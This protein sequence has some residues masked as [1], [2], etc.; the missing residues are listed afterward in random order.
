M[1]VRVHPCTEP[2]AEAESDTETEVEYDTELETE[3]RLGCGFGLDPAIALR[4]L[5]EGVRQGARERGPFGAS[6][7]GLG[8]GARTRPSEARS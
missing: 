5:R 6:A 7:L 8:I 1:R 4:A 2:G 3:V